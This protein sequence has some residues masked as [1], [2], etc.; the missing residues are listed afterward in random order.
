ME[1]KEPLLESDSLDIKLTVRTDHDGVLFY[2][3]GGDNVYLYS[4]IS[5][6]LLLFGYRHGTYHS[7]VTLVDDGLNVCDGRWKTLSFSK[8]GDFYG[9]CCNG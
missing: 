9:S 5:K 3:D 1:L 2:A 7:L 6:G 4:V 8:V